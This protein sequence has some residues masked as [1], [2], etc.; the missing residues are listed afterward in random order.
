[1]RVL[2]SESLCSAI[3]AVLCIALAKQLIQMTASCYCYTFGL[4][5][6]PRE[7]RLDLI[8]D[9]LC[10]IASLIY[11][12]S[13]QKYQHKQLCYS[14]DAFPETEILLERCLSLHKLSS[15]MALRQWIE[16]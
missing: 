7:F 1:M 9:S 14:Y 5:K 4:K 6:H 2:T 16:G 13:Q 10:K 15:Y 12:F 3:P 11:G 8:I